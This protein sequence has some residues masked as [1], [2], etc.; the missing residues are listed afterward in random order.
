MGLCVQSR[1]RLQ[2]SR[3][4]QPRAGPFLACGG[5]GFGHPPVRPIRLRRR[6]SEALGEGRHDLD[7]PTSASLPL[8]RR[9][10]QLAALV[11]GSPLWGRG[12]VLHPRLC[13]CGT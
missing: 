11:L 1:R 3:L 7:T 10:C 5:A 4:Q 8:A 6:L 12:R 9:P 2:C 13:H